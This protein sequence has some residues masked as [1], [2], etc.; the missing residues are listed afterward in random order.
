MNIVFQ[1]I[2]KGNVSSPDMLPLLFLLPVISD[3]F[4]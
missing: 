4:R 1:N 2:K 3:F